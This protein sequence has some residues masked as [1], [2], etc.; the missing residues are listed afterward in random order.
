MENHV[1]SSPVDSNSRLEIFLITY[2][3]EVELAQ[4][5]AMCFAEG[6]PIRDIPFTILNNKSTD[7]TA[8]IV[9]S[10]C[11]RFPSIR[12]VVHSRNIGGN[13]NI[14]RAYELAT[15]DYVWVI[16]DDDTFDFSAWSEVEAAMRVGADAILVANYLKPRQNVA[17]LLAQ[18]TFVPATIYKTALISDTI[19][20]NMAHNIANLFPHLALAC[21]VINHNRKIQIL[22]DWVVQ[23]KPNPDSSY[24][25][26]L[27]DDVSPVIKNMFWALGFSNSLHLIQDPTLQRKIRNELWFNEEFPCR[28]GS[29]CKT[30]F[31]HFQGNRKCIGDVFSAYGAIQTFVIGCLVWNREMFRRIRSR[32]GLRGSDIRG[33]FV[34]LEGTH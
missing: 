1:N 18:M 25:R 2:N 16:C 12:H 5:L 20:V 17:Q 32:L 21:D 11:K 23:M 13:A 28:V 19:F 9:E 7:R 8:E 3:R 26:A 29:L 33:W 27:D 31:R 6:S 30:I 22:D 14:V 10:Y 15:R 24:L 34:K 4:T